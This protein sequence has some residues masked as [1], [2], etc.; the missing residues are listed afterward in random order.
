M[1]VCAWR[2]STF[3]PGI[4]SQYLGR[5]PRTEKETRAQFVA[6]PV[7]RMMYLGGYGFLHWL[8]N[9]SHPP[10]RLAKEAAR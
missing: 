4:G 6:F 8:L 1:Y 10:T 2:V 9:L 5:G 7:D 3:G